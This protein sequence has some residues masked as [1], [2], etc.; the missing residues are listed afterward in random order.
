MK[1]KSQIRWAVV[2]YRGY[3]NHG[4]MAFTRGHVIEKVLSDHVRLRETPVWS[5]LTDAQFWRKLKRR[6][7]WSVRRVSL[8]VAR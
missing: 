3:I 1:H 2:G 8:R 4:Y 5:G 6:R 7:G